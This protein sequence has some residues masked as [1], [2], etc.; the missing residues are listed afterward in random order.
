MSKLAIAKYLSKER[1]KFIEKKKKKD[2]IKELWSLIKDN[3]IVTDKDKLLKEFL[4]REKIM[5]TGIGAGIAIPHVKSKYVKDFV[6]CVGIS[7]KGVDF[8]SLDKMPAKILVMIAA[9]E[10]KHKEYL[11]ILSKIVL[12]LKEK[13]YREKIINA[14]SID[15]IYNLLVER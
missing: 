13:K 5:S 8:D 3:E 6:I 10:D 12:N 15:E 11:K 7:K 1:I 9:P 2:V 4:E 14:S